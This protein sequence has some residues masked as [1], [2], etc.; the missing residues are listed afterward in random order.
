MQTG[1]MGDLSFTHD[2]P[3]VRLWV[4]FGSWHSHWRGPLLRRDRTLS[5][6]LFRSKRAKTR[7]DGSVLGDARTPEAIANAAAHGMII[8]VVSEGKRFERRRPSRAAADRV[9]A[10]PAVA[11]SAKKDELDRYLDTP[12]DAE[13]AGKA[14]VA[15]LAY[16]AEASRNTNC[17]KPGALRYIQGC[18]ATA[19][20]ERSLLRN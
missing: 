9:H 4:I 16:S 15:R 14:G 8:G 18:C 6:G 3:V 20:F 17:G 11:S 1:R 2:I 13:A 7:H 19:C 12:Y 5:G 10:E